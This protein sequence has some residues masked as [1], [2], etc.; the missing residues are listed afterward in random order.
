MRVAGRIKNQVVMILINSGSSH[1][2]LDNNVCKR[3][4]CETKY[5]KGI[6]VTIANEDSLVTNEIYQAFT[7]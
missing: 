2:F 4:R 6:P 5:I 1:N 3:L 7:L